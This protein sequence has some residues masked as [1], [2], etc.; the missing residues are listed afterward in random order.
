MVEENIG[1]SKAVEKKV[2]KTIEDK[3]LIES[4]VFMK[5]NEYLAENKSK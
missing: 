5:Q 2:S 1:V 4:M 3:A